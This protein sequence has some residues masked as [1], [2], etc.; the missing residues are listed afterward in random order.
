MASL[1]K[2][3]AGGFHAGAGKPWWITLFARVTPYLGSRAWEVQLK[4]EECSEVVPKE[5]VT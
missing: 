2:T 1:S 3:R 4:L 5:W